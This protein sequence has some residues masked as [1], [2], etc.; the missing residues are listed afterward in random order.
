MVKR[1]V[2]ILRKINHALNEHWHAL[3]V[4][5]VTNEP[6][7]TPTIYFLT[8]DTN[9]PAGGILVIYRHVDLLNSAGIRAFVLHQRRGFRCTWFAHYTCVTDVKSVKVGRGDLLVVPEMDVSL[10][11]KKPPGIRHVIF[12]QNSHLTWKRDA[13]QVIQHYNKS[14]DLAGVIVVSNHNADML[15]YAFERAP[16]RRIHLSIDPNL[17]HLGEG[18]P[19]ARRISYMPRRGGAD[20][21]KVLHLLR[22]RNVL[23]GWEVVPLDGLTHA[24][25]AEQLRTTRIF[26]AFTY[27]E[28]FGLP[29][30]EAMACGNYVVGYHGYG[31]QEFFFPEFSAPIGTGDILAFARAVENA[32]ICDRE[33]TSWCLD[34]GRA[35]SLF[36]LAEYSL[37]R[38]RNEVL[39]VYAEILG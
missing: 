9:I 23:D 5:P 29:A 6:T 4:I 36:V 26:M 24:E 18:F 27:Q 20:A 22:E 34:R 15:R 10:L 39:G 19:R 25:V 30:A 2:D 7:P 12:N 33:N 21:E 28:G 3:M 17:F 13:E 35:A 11:C 8:P 16:V 1:F 31:G 32:I 38:E 14:P 37:E